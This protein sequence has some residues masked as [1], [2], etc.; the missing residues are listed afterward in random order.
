MGAQLPEFLP[1]MDR[2]GRDDSNGG[3]ASM[4]QHRRKSSRKKFPLRDVAI[5]GSEASYDEGGVARVRH[6]H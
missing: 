5:E 4:K 6:K 1:L 2:S 3:V